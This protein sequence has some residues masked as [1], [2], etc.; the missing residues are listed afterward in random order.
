MVRHRAVGSTYPLVPDRSDATP[1][2]ESPAVAIGRQI[3]LLLLRELRLRRL[4]SCMAAVGLHD[5]AYRTNPVADTPAPIS[6]AAH[7]L[8]AKGIAQSSNNKS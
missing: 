5:A 3:S 2:A 1:T 6:L 4:L 8:G 7:A